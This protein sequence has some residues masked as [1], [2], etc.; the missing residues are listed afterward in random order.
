MSREFTQPFGCGL[1][2]ND[3]LDLVAEW[4]SELT[5]HDLPVNLVATVEETAVDEQVRINAMAAEPGDG[6]GSPWMI[7]HP[8]KVSGAPQV[9]P[10]R[11]P[12]LSE[13][14]REILAELGYSSTEID[15][16]A[17]QG[18]I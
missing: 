2:A 3:L 12:A 7:N 8:V 18:V 10:H 11:P 13:H 4:L 5:G 14:R 15:A 17:E 6:F 16:L 9:E 1:S